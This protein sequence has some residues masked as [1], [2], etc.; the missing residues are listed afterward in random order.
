MRIKKNLFIFAIIGLFL[1]CSIE[2]KGAE[3]GKV[4]YIVYDNSKSMVMNNR[5]W[6]A[7]AQYAVKA[8]CA[9]SNLEDEIRFYC[10]GDFENK[11]V[12]YNKDIQTDP[13]I[14]EN[15]F[16]SIEKT[17]DPQINRERYAQ[18][19]DEIEFN[20]KCTYYTGI[21]QAIT[22]IKKCNGEKW[23]VMF[24]D[25]DIEDCEGFEF[26]NNLYQDLNNT[27]VNVCF[28]DLN[29]KASTD[30]VA[31]NENYN[32]NVYR[33][34]E[35]GNE[36]IIES[37][38]S[39]T[40]KI[41]GKRSLPEGS[42]CIEETEEPNGEKTIKLNFDIPVS[43]VVLLLQNKQKWP[44][45][46]AIDGC[47]WSLEIAGKQNLEEEKG[48]YGMIGEFSIGMNEYR[49]R[50]D[51]S[52]SIRI[53]A[54]TNYTIYYT[55]IGEVKL[56]V[57]QDYD[58]VKEGTYLEGEYS[59]CL[60]YLNPATGEPINR[61]AELLKV[62][63]GRI[64]IDGETEALNLGQEV[65][66]TAAAGTK[67]FC[68]FT[69][70]GNTGTETIQFEENMKK[71]ELFITTED[72]IFYYNRLEQQENAVLL[73]IISG[74]YNV[75]EKF[76]D[77]E[78]QIEF[79]QGDKICKEVTCEKKYDMEN[80]VWK[81]Y[82]QVKNE[83]NISG[84][85]LC[86]IQ[87]KKEISYYKEPIVYYGEIELI[88]DAEDGLF[89]MEIQEDS[90]TPLLLLLPGLTNKIPIKYYWQEEELRKKDIDSFHVVMNITD[91]NEEEIKKEIE[92]NPIKIKGSF[93]NIFSQPREIQ[94]KAEAVYAVYGKEYISNETAVIK[95]EEI[96]AWEKVLAFVIITF[97]FLAMIVGSY[98]LIRLLAWIFSGDLLLNKMRVYRCYYDGN[99][100]MQESIKVKFTPCV[101]LLLDFYYEIKIRMPEGISSHYLYLEMRHKKNVC[102]IRIKKE[103]SF[104][105]KLYIGGKM[106]KDRF[107]TF[108]QGTEMILELPQEKTQR[109]RIQQ[110]E[111]L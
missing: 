5:D 102:K 4:I 72:N 105:G 17:N 27:D 67:E 37:I 107:E 52:M 70:L 38:L 75:T 51:Y 23:V 58:E 28:V 78:P 29:P 21:H 49:S 92:D 76:K 7:Q 101:L 89:A 15:K 31:T 111:E 32:L 39:V 42:K 99:I 53:P 10:I 41:Y 6:G 106:I 59:L 19:L 55:P 47:Q 109:I 64:S 50:N 14:K 43:N 24:T 20:G 36:S 63:T 8:F 95:I 1:N 61:N 100:W 85:L 40:E 80:N 2:T 56:N 104:D 46:A 68:A 90:I 73:S 57:L 81:I 54:G 34:A 13:N 60:D 35:N 103:K 12:K 79:W 69:S 18:K 3:E 48:P 26:R 71:N 83:R 74:N 96:P 91:D 88:M 44:A 108:N 82:P 33:L 65:S 77:I 87:L 84:N 94:I 86:K 30:P 93:K 66:K 62:E 16:I 11:Y 25:G 9:M 45:G 97:V 110:G 22:D 98:D